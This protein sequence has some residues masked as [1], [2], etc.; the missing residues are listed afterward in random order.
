MKATIA[1]KCASCGKPFSAFMGDIETCSNVTYLCAACMARLLKCWSDGGWTARQSV[2]ETG[3]HVTDTMKHDLEVVLLSAQTIRIVQMNNGIS[4]VADEAWSA[5]NAA[6]RR[7]HDWLTRRPVNTEFLYGGHRWWPGHGEE[8]RAKDLAGGEPC[9]L[10]GKVV[11]AIATEYRCLNK[12]VFGSME[13]KP[14]GCEMR[15]EY[16]GK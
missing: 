8:V 14:C 1:A 10:C 16:S 9:P 3:G 6:H 7:V 4:E 13:I 5:L 15:T 2:S 12:T 11:M